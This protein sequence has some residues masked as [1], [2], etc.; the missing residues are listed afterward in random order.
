MNVQETRV[1]SARSLTVK[2]IAG[3]ILIALLSLASYFIIE[4]LITAEQASAAVINVSGRQRMLAQKTVLLS[5]QLADATDA[6]QGARVRAELARTVAFMEMAHEGLVYGNRELGLPGTISPEA[7]AIIFDEPVLL[8]KRLMEYLAEAKAVIQ[9]PDAVTDSNPHVIRVVA[10]S[11][12]I[13]DSLNMLVNQFQRDSEARMAR[14]KALQAA[15]LSAML[16]VLVLEALFIFQPAALT[17]R[18]E[19]EN[20]AAANL[21]LQRLSNLDGLTGIANRRLFEEF[22]GQEWQRAVRQREPLTLIMI[23]V[24]HF[25]FY[26]DT[27]GHQAG[28]DC[29][30]RLA[31]VLKANVKRTT[32]FVARYGGEEF[33]VVLPDTGAD[34]A[35]E[36]AER[37][38]AAV[39]ALAIPHSASPVSDVV[40]VSLGT[41]TVLPGPGGSPADI[42]AMADQAMY[43]AKQQGRNRFVQAVAQNVSKKGSRDN[44]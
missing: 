44:G 19:T 22:L 10:L 40:T 31:D 13:V 21:E 8:E 24:D 12:E 28:D 4:H 26:N 32:D 23:D 41:A 42:V 14:L 38:R 34:G 2:Y 16:V 7:R 6:V 37:L 43:R 39:A 18:R 20:L 9:A 15:V 35:A 30:R 17:I 11:G 3:L 27:Y 33:I 29:L 36:V 1:M 25:K 5:L